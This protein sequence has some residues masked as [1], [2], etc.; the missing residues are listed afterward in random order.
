MVC[1]S[2]VNKTT[3]YSETAV[4]LLCYPG[5][6]NDTSWPLGCN[7][8][9]VS[10]YLCLSTIF[11]LSCLITFLRLSSKAGLAAAWPPPVRNG[12]LFSKAISPETL[13]CICQKEQSVFHLSEPSAALTKLLGDEQTATKKSLGSARFTRSTRSTD[14]QDPQDP[15][16]PRDPQDPQIHK[17]HKIHKIQRSTRSTYPQDPQIHKIHKIHKIHEIH[18][19]HRSTE[20]PDLTRSQLCSCAKL[21]TVQYSQM[22]S[23]DLGSPCGKPARNTRH[24]TWRVGGGRLHE[25]WFGSFS[26]TAIVF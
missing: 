17:I 7:L 5:E 24:L 18:K 2:S 22:N 20:P 1:P 13:A 15:Q 26:S 14:P 21:L 4:C 12:L 6:G 8:M 23:A 16:D 25:V 9:L 10:S 11:G 3:D 19:I